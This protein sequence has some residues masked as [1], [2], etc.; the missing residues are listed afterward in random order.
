MFYT[1]KRFPSHLFSSKQL[2]RDMAL[3]FG[4]FRLS[5]LYKPRILHLIHKYLVT[6]F[7]KHTHKNHFCKCWK[8]KRSSSEVSPCYE[9]DSSPG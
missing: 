3:S 4:T 6:V 8:C 7:T 1:S 2:G 5:Q 9:S